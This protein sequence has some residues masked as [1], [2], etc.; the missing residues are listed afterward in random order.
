LRVGWPAIGHGPKRL[1]FLL[2]GPIVGV[3]HDDGFCAS[4]RPERRLRPRRWC[5]SFRW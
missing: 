5:T 1:P 3:R 2:L 4:I